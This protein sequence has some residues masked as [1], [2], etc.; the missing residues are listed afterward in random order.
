MSA[1]KT[2]TILYGSPNLISKIS[3]KI[4]ES[5]AADGFET[6]RESLLNG[7]EE[8]SLTKGG[9]FKKIAGLQTALKVS[10]TPNGNSI[11]FQAGIGIFGQQFIPTVISMLFF[12]PVLL[13]QIWGMVQQAKL[14]DKALSI[15]QQT[16]NEYNNLSTNSTEGKFC[17]N[18]GNRMGVSAQFCSSCGSRL[19]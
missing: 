14:D 5:F 2:S 10:L 9:L 15:A 1:F 17:T 6:N 8:I 18:C 7:S 13:T 11:S 12:W 4:C 16:I 19:P 3:D